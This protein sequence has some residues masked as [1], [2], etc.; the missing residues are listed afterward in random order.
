MESFYKIIVILGFS[1]ILSML[2]FAAFSDVKQDMM[3]STLFNLSE[4]ATFLVKLGKF[5]FRTMPRTIS[6]LFW[7]LI[8]AGFGRC[9]LFSSSLLL[10]FTTVF[11]SVSTI[12]EFD[13]VQCHRPNNQGFLVGIEPNPG[14]PGNSKVSKC[15]E[16]TQARRAVTPEELLRGMENL[17]IINRKN[18][19]PSRAR[20]DSDKIVS[21]AIKLKKSIKKRLRQNH[22]PSEFKPQMWD[23][24]GVPVKHQIDPSQFE[25]ISGFMRRISAV[26]D[27]AEKRNSIIS[28]ALVGAAKAEIENACSGI[29]SSLQEYYDRYGDYFV[30]FV[31]FL[32]LAFLLAKFGISR[33]L[34]TYLSIIVGI[35]FFADKT[36]FHN[37][38]LKIVD[39][40][41]TKTWETQDWSDSFKHIVTLF[42]GYSLFKNFGSFSGS[43]KSATRP[44]SQIFDLVRLQQ[45]IPEIV[46]SFTELCQVILD[47]AAKFLGFSSWTIVST[48]N[49]EI[50]RWVESVRKF[51]TDYEKGMYVHDADLFDLI[52]KF[53]N[54]SFL[55]ISKFGRGELSAVVSH[56]VRPLM[57]ELVRI[58]DVLSREGVGSHRV[59]QKPVVISFAGMSAIGK[60]YLMRPFSSALLA[61]VLPY[62]EHDKL[63]DHL[64]S[65][66]YV[67]NPTITHWNG[68]SGQEVTFYDERDLTLAGLAQAEN[69]CT[70]LI[71]NAN[72]FPVVLNMADIESKG[73]VYFRSKIIICNTN[74]MDT[75]T[76]SK[77]FVRYPEAFTNRFDFEIQCGVSDKYCLDADVHKPPTERRLDQSKLPQ[78]KGFTYDV[79]EFHIMKKVVDESHPHDYRLV[80]SEV[81]GFDEL[82]R[83]CRDKYMSHK[84]QCEEVLREDKV[85][86]S[87]GFNLRREFEPQMFCDHTHRGVY[88]LV[89]LVLNGKEEEA[90]REW[91]RVLS[92]R[93]KDIQWDA[94]DGEAPA[95]ASLLRGRVTYR[96]YKTILNLAVEHYWFRKLVSEEISVFDK[97]N[98]SNLGILLG[99]VDQ[100]LQ[101][102][103]SKFW[104]W[105][106]ERLGCF[107]DFASFSFSSQACL[108]IG[109][110]MI[111]VG[112][113]YMVFSFIYNLLGL[114]EAADN[115]P[116]SKDQQFEP[117][118]Y[119]DKALD[120]VFNK[121]WKNN[122]YSISF[123]EDGHTLGWGFFISGY[124]F[125]L[126][127]HY[128]RTW[129]YREKPDQPIILRNG[130]YVI[131]L[132][133]SD[134]DDYDIISTDCVKVEIGRCR[135]HSD[136]SHLIA[137][138]NH[139]VSRPRGHAMMVRM[140]PEMAAQGNARTLQPRCVFSP[141]TALFS[142]RYTG[143][144]GKTYEHPVSLS[145]PISTQ[146]GECGLPIFLVDPTTRSN[147]FI[148]FHVAGT[149]S[150]GLCCVF[151]IVSNSDYSPQGFTEEVMREVGTV[152][153]PVGTSGVSSIRKSPLHGTWMKPNKAPA[154][155]RPFKN[156]QGERVDPMQQALSKYQMDRGSIEEI[157]PSMLTACTRAAC[158]S[159]FSGHAFSELPRKLSF[160]DA[161]FGIEGRHFVDA[162][163]RGTS[164]G[165][166]WNMFPRP[167]FKGK[168]RFFG[169]GVSLSQGPDYDILMKE[170]FEAE[171]KLSQGEEPD[172][173]F[174]DSLKDELRPI[175]K[176]KTGQTRMFCPSPIVL[177]ILF[178]MYFGDLVAKFMEDRIL[179]EHAVGVNPYSEE[180]DTLARKLLSGLN[181]GEN[182]D[183][184]AFLAGDFSKFDASQ[185][186]D[187]LEAI[188]RSIIE[189]FDDREH[190][191]V[192]SHL[193]SYVTRSKHVN[194]R[195]VYQWFGKL[196][197]GIFLTTLINCLYVGILFRLCWIKSHGGS[198]QCLRDFSKSVKLVA[199]GDDNIA[200]VAQHARDIFNQHTLSM[201][202]KE[203][204]HI[205][206]SD[207]KDSFDSAFRSL[208]DITFL[209]RSFRYEERVGRYVAP[210]DLKTILE[211]PFWTKKEGVD[212]VWRDNV[213]NALR[214]LSLHESTVF[215]NW[216]PVVV[217]ESSR[218][219]HHPVLTDRNSLLDEVCK[220]PNPWMKPV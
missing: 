167:G 23:S 8:E 94:D 52:L 86:F 87:R 9:I 176:V 35:S 136:I 19:R 44:F 82:V 151:D 129:R 149:G 216:V 174:C 105:C 98:L 112:V 77:G 124:S 120:D 10:C 14:P 141:Y 56:V 43:V 122:Y 53:E 163:Q 199:F 165:Y 175:E 185:R 173:F 183:T 75:Y 181:L 127:E 33:K 97:L 99:T 211:M 179:G 177:T 73:S 101:Y 74:I 164:P 142:A 180:W 117:Q 49:Q 207:S 215:D 20:A 203:L 4:C 51:K 37:G 55:L 29:W 191:V 27:N 144:S 57:N 172:F 200:S 114:D 115:S 36:G 12:P 69:A 220:M 91:R 93:I 66:V 186:S 197:S 64:D 209:K 187:I 109:I 67:R 48:G 32:V 58:R 169:Q 212:Q 133:V 189:F 188:G 18:Y 171:E 204:G 60:S 28:G 170:V 100:A 103:F 2:G 108:S 5:I 193:W 90:R 152:P 63:R 106:G 210:L 214:E 139:V 208:K 76:A 78:G 205:Y 162:V 194:G 131:K 79:L 17:S 50:K 121:V 72:V 154:R 158:V 195:V 81:I 25:E 104:T 140:S 26:V 30:T 24:F 96:E 16:G 113:G 68:Y 166:P 65:F 184:E 31:G 39:F 153:R 118:I 80:E 145:Y 219:G 218:A 147:K 148:G 13:F 15:A 146:P 155:L 190:D 130:D 206:T 125:V 156:E 41:K 119:Q 107:S 70:E 21:M 132:K 7:L 34:I 84:E 11:M 134:F 157:N 138:S 196:S 1:V 160:E 61:S 128:V 40:I 92:Y 143:K 71:R 116:K 83:R 217:T 161:C 85:A 182:P 95:W 111:G 54:E 110:A 102:H 88:N 42:M 123:E 135:T 89:L 6:C 168:E 38:I 192:R 3:I 178:K 45:N 59:R 126:P 22:V 46:A 201:H 213:D 150:N 62:A 159:N 198:V 202:M 47:S 137:N